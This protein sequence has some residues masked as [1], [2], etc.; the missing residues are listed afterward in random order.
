[1]ALAILAVFVFDIDMRD[2]SN[3]PKSI[4]NDNDST[5][6]VVEPQDD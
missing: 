4:F 3:S 5:E 2:T 1:M 6:E